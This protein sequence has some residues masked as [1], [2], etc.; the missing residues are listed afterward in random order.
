[1][2]AVCSGGGAVALSHLGFRELFDD[3]YATSAGIMN[4][5]YFL[6]GQAELG[7]TVYYDCLSDGRFLNP[8]RFWKVLDVDFVIDH[9]VREL[10]PLN[11]DKILS[12]RS[13]LFV[14]AIDKRS[15]KGMMIDAKKAGAPFL[16]VCRAAMA[17]PV[18]YN[19]AVH[20]NGY[21]CMDGGLAIPFPIHEAIANGCTDLLVL[22]TRPPSYVCQAPGWGSRLLFDLMCAHGHGNLRQTYFQQGACS[23]AARDLAFGRTPAASTVNIATICTSEDEVVQRTT[24]NREALRAAA[25]RYGRKTLQVFG[26]PSEEWDLAPLHEVAV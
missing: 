2:R 10:K 23:T 13:Q 19:R 4:A 18:L 8:K 3:V 24:M 17:I 15:G 26:A 21:R 25:V 5:S 9:V 7:I 22:L 20:I 1:M 11:V 16:E 14:A 6:S 12:A